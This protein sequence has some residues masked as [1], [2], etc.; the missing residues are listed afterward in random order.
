MEDQPGK[1]DGAADAPKQGLNRIAAGQGRTG[2][3][4]VV[5]AC[6]QQFCDRL[7]SPRSTVCCSQSSTGPAGR[8]GEPPRPC[9][10]NR[11]GSYSPLGARRSVE[12]GCSSGPGWAGG[13]TRGG[14]RAPSRQRRASPLPTGRTP[15]RRDA[16][17]LFPVEGHSQVVRSAPAAGGRP[18]RGIEYPFRPAALPA[19]G[20]PAQ[21]RQEH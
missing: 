20:H 15:V 18:G 21:L 8:G 13:W 14:A 16:R 3:P 12:G 10:V 1:A 9:C 17:A 5:T 11:G 19:S 2:Q 4:C 6:R 7:T